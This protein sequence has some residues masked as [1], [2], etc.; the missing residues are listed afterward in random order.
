MDS[1]AEEAVALELVPPGRMI[2]TITVTLFRS[3]AVSGQTRTAELMEGDNPAAAL[4]APRD[5]EVAAAGEEIKTQCQ[6]LDVNTRDT[7][8]T[9]RW[10]WD[11]GE[12]GGHPS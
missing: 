3:P 2:L 7:S 12:I 4:V 9:K 5:V 1:L 11:C 8:A 6:Q 10:R